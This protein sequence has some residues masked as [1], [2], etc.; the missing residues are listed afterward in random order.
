MVNNEKWG[1]IYIANYLA[2]SKL[3]YSSLYIFSRGSKDSRVKTKSLN[4]QVKGVSL[5]VEADCIF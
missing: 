3:A 2:A 4:E 1:V 5:F